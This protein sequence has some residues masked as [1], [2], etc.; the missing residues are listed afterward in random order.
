MRIRNTSII[1]LGAVAMLS[2]TAAIAS[3]QDT[4]KAKTTSA[5]RIRVSKEAGGEVVAPT[6][7]MRVDT[8][9]LYR[10]DTVRVNG[11]VDTVTTTVTRY[12]TVTI[13]AP[14]PPPAVLR[15]PGGLYFGLGGGAA[16]L[17]GA[18]YNPN[19][20]GYTAQAQLGWQGLN[21]PF[22]IR[23]DANYVQPGEDSQYSNLGGDPDILNFNGDIKLALPIFN[24]LFGATPRFSLYAIGG[25]SY[26]MF[27]NLPLRLNPGE[28][29][30]TG[31]LNV[32][33]PNPNWNH[34]WGWNAGGGGSLM[35]GRTELFVESRMVAFNPTN[36][37]QARQFPIVLGFNIY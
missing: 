16:D 36:A 6:P 27:K 18:L 19:G 28:P 20:M 25:G 29:G 35:F 15:F 31:P 32:A 1:V 17:G 21:N 11:R 3:A 12:D 26:T 13:Q 14:P 34:M 24:H 9:T 33:L 4:T 7:T 5:K 22:G 2:V 23:V 30:G 37:P 8:V 10:S